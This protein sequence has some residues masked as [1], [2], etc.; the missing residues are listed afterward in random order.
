MQELNNDANSLLNQSF[1]VSQLIEN[2]N[3]IEDKT[4][5]IAGYMKS[6]GID[7]VALESQ[8]TVVQQYIDIISGLVE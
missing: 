3:D 7:M 1:V 5:E 4:Y 8:K 2:S 6:L